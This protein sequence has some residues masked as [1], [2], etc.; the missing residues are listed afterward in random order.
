MIVRE[1]PTHEEHL[2]NLLQSDNKQFKIAVTFLTEYN[3]F[4][5]FVTKNNKVYFAKSVTDKDGFI[6]INIPQGA[7]ELES[8]YDGIK[9]NIIEEGNFTEAIYLFTMK[10]KFSTLGSFQNFRDKN[11]FLVFYLM[12]VYEIF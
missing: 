10:P 5:I 2:A 1:K 9:K 8:L 7:Y 4:F 6:Q 3:G 12:I 11:L